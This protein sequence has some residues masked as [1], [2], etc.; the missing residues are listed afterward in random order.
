MQLAH[1][2]QQEKHQLFVT[3]LINLSNQSF[4][5]ASMDAERTKVNNIISKRTGV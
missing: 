2:Q 4:L 3:Q 1:S 5:C